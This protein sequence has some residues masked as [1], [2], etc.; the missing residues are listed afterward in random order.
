MGNA[1]L[2]LKPASERDVELAKQGQRLIMEALDRSR[3]QKIA[4]VTND[5][6]NL[7]PIELPPDML[8]FI[9][10][11]LGMMSQ[12]KVVS[13]VPND[14][15]LT[16][17]EVASFLNVSRPFVVKLIEEGKLN[18]KKVGRHRRIEFSEAK[19]LREEMQ[20]HSQKALRNLA[21]TSVDFGLET[22]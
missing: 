19:R 4:L 11:I 13:L 2:E 22:L 20:K 9:G 1:V 6:S 12:R 21:K 14:H 7:P 15:E 5:G 16:T 18:C 10:G 3:A 17:Q 8:R